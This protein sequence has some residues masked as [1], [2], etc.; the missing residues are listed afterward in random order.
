MRASRALA[1]A[2]VT[3]AA[4]GLSA[5]LAAAGGDSQ[6]NSQVHV[7]VNPHA[8]H[9]GGTLT[10]T[11]HGCNRGGTV[12]SNAFSQ[13]TLSAPREDSRGDNRGDNRD[14]RENRDNRGDNRDNN[15]ENTSTAT[16]RIHDHASPGHYNLAVRCNNNR[17]VA[18][19]QFTVL[20][21]R[22]AQGG[23]GGSMGPSSTEMAVGAGL[24]GTAAIGGT[25]FIAR[26]RRTVGART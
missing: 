24:V 22:G 20:S 6:D 4:V 15:R 7:S 10:I 16:A 23:L 18:T 26:R 17:N 5:P 12:T 21:G 14:S 1:V 11:V 13:V 9:Q 19:A 3:C 8:V 2:A 25:L